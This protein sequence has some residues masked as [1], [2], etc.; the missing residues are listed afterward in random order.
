VIAGAEI[1]TT[2]HVAYVL[3]HSLLVI[4]D[5]PVANK[6]GLPVRSG[7][8]LNSDYWVGTQVPRRTQFHAISA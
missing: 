5:I 4:I 6:E 7:K 8:L 1:D 2:Q 3:R